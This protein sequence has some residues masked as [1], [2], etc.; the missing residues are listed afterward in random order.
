MLQ[1]EIVDGNYNKDQF[2]DYCLA[3]K[4]YGD[5]LSQWSYEELKSAVNSFITYH[6]Q[7]DL[8]EKQEQQMKNQIQDQTNQMQNQ[9]NQINNINYYNNNN[10]NNSNN[11]V[12]TPYSNNNKYNLS[13]KYNLDCRKL[14][15][16][17]LSNKKVVITIKN[18]K[19]VETSIFKSNY[20][21]YEVYTDVTQ[22]QVIRRYSDFDWLRQTLKKSIQEFTAHQ[23]Q[24][25]KW[26]VGDLK[27]ILLSKE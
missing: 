6:Q 23:F 20:I 15:K 16:S 18:P 2:I 5:D 26:V 8:R 10:N 25:K 1:R 7:E 3:L 24:G 11:N 9:M 17:Q 12:N 27:M 19:A 4:P 22:W 13:K 21:S 14:E